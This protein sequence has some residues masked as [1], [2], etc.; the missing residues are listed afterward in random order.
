MQNEGSD[1]STRRRMI[2]ASRS[3]RMQI[4]EIV[5]EQGAVDIATLTSRFSCSEAAIRSDLLY[6]SQLFPQLERIRGGI[7]YIDPFENTYFGGS[8]RDKTFLEQKQA[9]AQA[10]VCGYKDNSPILELYDLVVLGPGTTTFQICKQ[11]SAVGSN[12]IICTDN[13]AIPEV[14]GNLS[15]FFIGGTFTRD[16]WA[17]TGKQAEKDFENFLK[18][19]HNQVNKAVLGASGITNTG[20]VFV[21]NASETGILSK[22]IE[23]APVVVFVA[24]DAKIGKVDTS[25]LCNLNELAKNEKTVKLV[26]S[27]IG[28]TE[29]KKEELRQ[30]QER[31]R[32]DS[33]EVIIVEEQ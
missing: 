32:K 14:A 28:S 19:H 6:L 29:Q 9:I 25:H 16:I 2:D 5:I 33:V 17:T 15:L 26:T 3:R 30:F 23:A 8:L 18:E 22:F 11:M 4:L 31:L 12:Y 13:L 27:N 1:K 10:V 21:H 20:G 7:R 24:S